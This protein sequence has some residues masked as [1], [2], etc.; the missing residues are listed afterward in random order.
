[1]LRRCV[2]VAEAWNVTCCFVGAGAAKVGNK[3]GRVFEMY[4]RSHEAKQM[5]YGF[6]SRA[7]QVDLLRG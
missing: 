7:P 5:A 6:V 1:M 3:D 4:P 2:T